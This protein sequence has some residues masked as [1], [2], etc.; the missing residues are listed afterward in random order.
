MHRSLLTIEEPRLFNFWSTVNSHG[1]SD[2]APFLIDKDR[3]SIEVTLRLAR[4]RLVSVRL[5]APSK[6]IQAELRSSALLTVADKHQVGRIVRDFLRM[7][8]D[9][10]PFYAM[11][12]GHPSYRWVIGKGAGR[13]M[14]AASVFEDVVKM[15]CTTNCNW[16]LTKSMTNNLVNL[17]GE[18]W[19]GFRAFPTP[20]A[21]AGVSE[22]FVRA[23]IRAGYRSPFLIEFAQ[24]V[25]SH[26]LDVESWRKV[27]LTSEELSKNLRSIKGV[28]EYA[29]GNLMRLLG[30]YDAMAFDSWVR[31]EFY[32][33]HKNGR[34]VSDKTITKHYAEFAEWK[35]LFFWV[36]MT[37]DWFK[38][39]LPF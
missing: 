5:S 3:Q 26:K 13:L 15:I 33:K 7:D 21:L 14:R 32:K 8:E 2:L 6:R 4:H 29:A 19:K 31:A 23:E 30:H 18:E 36:D 17:L 20:E 1:W 24:R 11:V 28:G 10:R 12:R 37:E 9:Y 38:K 27:P 39:K 35:G 16:S 22:K 25:A 34:R